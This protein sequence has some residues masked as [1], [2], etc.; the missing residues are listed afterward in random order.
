[1]HATKS[2][3]I[4]GLTWRMRN[5]AASR[6]LLVGTGM[7]MAFQLG[8]LISFFAFYATR[9]HSIQIQQVL[10]ISGISSPAR[11]TMFFIYRPSG[12]NKA[13]SVTEEFLF[14]FRVNKQIDPRVY[15]RDPQICAIGPAQILG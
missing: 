7:Q 14:G 6:D 11:F 12:D 9:C 2:R 10:E 3:G 1:M 15:Q 8:R 13:A 4:A 5:A